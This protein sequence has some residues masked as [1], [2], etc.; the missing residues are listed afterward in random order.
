MYNLGRKRALNPRH[1]PRLEVREN[2]F[3]R[4]RTRGRKKMRFL[5]LRHPKLALKIIKTDWTLVEKNLES[6]IFNLSAQSLSLRLFI[7]SG[8]CSKNKNSRH[9]CDFLVAS[10]TWKR[11]TS[12]NF[13]KKSWKF[14]RVGS[15]YE[16]FWISISSFNAYYFQMILNS[17]VRENRRIVKT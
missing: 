8:C 5:H 12:G 3:L 10:W 17:Q 13:G 4:I 2:S 14:F 6:L 1:I 15:I 9:F 7:S 16:S 11:W